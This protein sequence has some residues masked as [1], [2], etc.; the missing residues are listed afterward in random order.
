M[1]HDPASLL[2]LVMKDDD[3]IKGCA[4]GVKEGSGW[5]RKLLGQ[6]SLHLPTF[7]AVNGE[8]QVSEEEINFSLLQFCRGTGIS[9]LN[10]DGRWG[11]DFSRSD[12][13][14]DHIVRTFVEFEMRTDQT[15][16][17]ILASMDKY[18]RKNI[19]RAERNGVTVEIDSSLEG[20]SRLRELQLVSADRATKRGNP[21]GV[22]D[23][24]YFLKIQKLLYKSG[25]GEV[26][27][28]KREGEFIAGLAYLFTQG[29]WRSRCVRGQRPKG[30]RTTLPIFFSSG[31]CSGLEKRVSNR[32]TLGV[33]LTMR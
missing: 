15:E 18:H 23:Q 24:T 2:F 27:F 29:S 22:R 16:E 20:L 11:R 32:S 9:R 5:R 12:R 33:C 14:A 19:R 1:D 25:L 28:A 17:A 10:I 6:S 13:F 7:P 8:L 26:A 31:S 3:S 21:F 30:T 4:V